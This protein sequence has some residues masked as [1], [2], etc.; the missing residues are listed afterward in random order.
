M[1]FTKGVCDQADN[2]PGYRIA[3]LTLMNTATCVGAVILGLVIG[4]T[5]IY[6]SEIVTLQIAF[7]VAGFYS[8][9]LA[10]NGL[11]AL[12]IKR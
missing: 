11:P 12:K 6:T 5:G 7:V 10:A 4:I 1:P 8:M 3:Y 9:L 2:L